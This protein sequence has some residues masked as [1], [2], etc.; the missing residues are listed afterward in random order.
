[1]Q[2]LPK[3]LLIKIFRKISS[4]YRPILRL[5]CK[6]WSLLIKDRRVDLPYLTWYGTSILEYLKEH[7]I[8]DFTNPSYLKTLFYS[9]KDKQACLDYLFKFKPVL[10]K[11]TTALA[12]SLDCESAK[13]L[14]ERGC[15]LPD[16]ITIRRQK[17]DPVLI[18]YAKSLNIVVN[19]TLSTMPDEQLYDIDIEHNKIMIQAR[20]Y[21]LV[22][23]GNLDLIKHFQPYKF[24]LHTRVQGFKLAERRGH[25]SVIEYFK[26][27]GVS[28]PSDYPKFID[29]EKLS[30][31]PRTRNLLT[32]IRDSFLFLPHK[33]PLLLRYVFGRFSV[34]LAE[35]LYSLGY[36]KENSTFES[37]IDTL[38][39]TSV[40]LNDICSMISWCDSHNIKPNTRIILRFDNPTLLDFCHSKNITFYDPKKGQYADVAYSTIIRAGSRRSLDWLYAHNYKFRINKCLLINLIYTGSIQMLNWFLDKGLAKNIDHDMV[41]NIWKRNPNHLI[42]LMLARHFKLKVTSLDGLHEK[43]RE[44]LESI[45]YK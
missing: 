21:N 45:G 30:V 42:L 13:F 28:I 26:S 7:N 15:E 9:K 25:V 35:I 38:Y 8:T 29:I 17:S 12:F 31:T 11:E 32:Y 23:H 3:C 14:I 34:E 36:I 39:N 4:W 6:H 2:A 16:K 22:Y 10:T 40:S 1:M 5:V 43:S 44:F 20:F 37:F 18:E 19:Y 27:V 33:Q 41:F 24:D